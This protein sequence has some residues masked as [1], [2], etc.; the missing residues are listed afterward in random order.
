M[1]RHR[2]LLKRPWI[3]PVGVV[4]LVAAH[5]IILRYVVPRVVLSAAVLTGVIVLV[6][7][8]HGGLLRSLF[9]LFRRQSRH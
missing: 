6:V 8:K 2:R 3:L 1:K 4:A 5:G 7:I 9:A